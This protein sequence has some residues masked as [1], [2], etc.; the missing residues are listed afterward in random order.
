MPSARAR[1]PAP[2]GTAPRD[3]D[4]NRGWLAASSVL[5]RGRKAQ[6]DPFATKHCMETSLGI[7]GVYGGALCLAHA[8]LPDAR[9]ATGD[10]WG[11]DGR[12]FDAPEPNYHIVPWIAEF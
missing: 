3:I 9:E 11:N 2:K 4:G 8:L 7:V 10:Y 5:K 1:S 12:P 6:D